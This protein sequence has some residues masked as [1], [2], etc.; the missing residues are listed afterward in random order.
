[1]SVFSLYSAYYDLLY[2]DKDYS[3]E[4]SYVVDRLTHVL[5]RSPASIL[6]LGCG[7]G[8][9]AQY[10]DKQGIQVAGVDL[11]Q[12]MIEQ[13]KKRLPRASFT[14]GDVRTIQ[15]GQTF[16]SVVSL[17]HVASY[18]TTNDDIVSYLK[19]AAGHL[20]AGGA[21]LFDFWYGPAVLAQKPTVRVK[22]MSDDRVSVWRSAEPQ[23]R[24][25]DC[26]VEV[27]YE[28]LIEDKAT[29]TI[30]RLKEVHPM[31]YFFLPELRY[32]LEQAGF[33]SATMLFEE[34]LTTASPSEAT[35]GVTAIA[36]KR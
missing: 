3:A 35:W 34:W 9:H 17:F 5:G 30:E 13:A 29:K 20:N 22:R 14:E 8:R 33:D 28:V 15:L 23:H 18:Q 16:D 32:F 25:N 36:R 7:T 10:F 11:S 27:H 21:F 1:M 4:S 6:E 12:T 2:K 24:A 19:T 26:V 31:R